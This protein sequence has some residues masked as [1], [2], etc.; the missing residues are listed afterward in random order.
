M[1]R[2]VTSPVSVFILLLCLPVRL[3]AQFDSVIVER[4]PAQAQSRQELDAYLDIVQSHE[5]EKIV[6]LAAR[7]AQQFPDSEFLGHVHRLEMA[8]HLVLNDYQNSIAAGEKALKLN[9]RD[10]NALLTLAKVL[11]NGMKETDSS[12]ILDKAENY[13]RQAIEEISAL[14]APRTLPLG[15]FRRVTAQMKASAHEAL[16][17][18]AFKRGRYSESV[19]EFEKSTDQNPLADGALFYRLGMAYLLNR[20]PAQAKIAL[21]RA[22][23]LG[24][25]VV[26][27]KAEEQLAKIR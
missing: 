1:P 19:A 8:A 2:L 22:S 7:L 15:E 14:K 11:P 27:K 9:P 26:R 5:P 13:A 20:N 10:L 6:S 18:I 24:P 12:A 16:G 17:I 3:S 21:K 23:E 25:E 4:K